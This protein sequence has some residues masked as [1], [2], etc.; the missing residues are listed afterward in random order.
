MDSLVESSVPPTRLPAEG[1]ECLKRR[2]N[3]QSEFVLD[4]KDNKCG[5]CIGYEINCKHRPE[6]CEKIRRHMK[7]TGRLLT[8]E[9]GHM[10]FEELLPKFE[11]PVTRLPNSEKLNQNQF[12]A[13]VSHA[14]HRG[15]SGTRSLV[16]AHMKNEDWNAVYEAIKNDPVRGRGG[17]KFPGR[18]R[19][20]ATQFAQV[21]GHENQP[22]SKTDK[23]RSI[24]TQGQPSILTPVHAARNLPDTPDTAKYYNRKDTK[25]Q[26]QRVKTSKQVQ[27]HLPG[28]LGAVE[29]TCASFRESTFIGFGNLGSL[30]WSTGVLCGTGGMFT[31]IIQAPPDG[32][33]PPT[34]KPSFAVVL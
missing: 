30:V 10:F 18:R 13:P 15:P 11:I 23:D 32:S 33:G 5:T 22:L 26:T 9:E 4:C 7:E 29:N 16:E 1:K 2:E 20:G 12:E 24:E 31:I 3:F 8:E 28:M 19:E 27:M 21:F 17:E 6:M 25:Q 34:I 14:Y